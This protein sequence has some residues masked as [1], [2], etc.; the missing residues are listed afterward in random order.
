MPSRCCQRGLPDNPR[1]PCH[2]VGCWAGERAL[3]VASAGRGSQEVRTRVRACVGPRSHPARA[4]YGTDPNG[5]LDATRVPA[6]NISLDG[7]GMNGLFAEPVGACAQ[8]PSLPPP[9][10][11]NQD[12]AALVA[13]LGMCA[14]AWGHCVPGLQA[15]SPYY[16]LPYVL[17]NFP[18][19][20]NITMANVGFRGSVLA[21]GAGE[22]LAP[23]RE[24]TAPPLH[25]SLRMPWLNARFSP[26]SP[27]QLVLTHSP[28]PLVMPG[29][30]VG[31]ARASG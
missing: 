2:R 3:P 9:T 21:P 27:S 25:T 30:G 11:T 29:C 17:W 14:A 15:S 5:T 7:F 18:N 12:P 31:G 6:T 24:D 4:G 16:V 28:W 23:A 10:H 19:A 20:K 22:Y 26:P 1:L 13:P 8:P